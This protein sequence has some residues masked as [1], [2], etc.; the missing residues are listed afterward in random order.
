MSDDWKP[1]IRQ[2]IYGIEH[3]RDLPS[4]ARRVFEGVSHAPGEALPEPVTLRRALA[5]ALASQ[6][7]LA[8]LYVV[9]GERVAMPHD[10]AALRAMLAELAALIDS[11][12]AQAGER[13]PRAGYWVP[14]T[15]DAG[16]GIALDAGAV[17]PAH[18]AGWWRLGTDPAAEARDAG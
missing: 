7:D 13:A 12:L 16:E 17:L 2:L 8:A 10:D 9:A 18:A 14:A 1:V 6:T 5:A 15:W 11:E 4:R 3:E